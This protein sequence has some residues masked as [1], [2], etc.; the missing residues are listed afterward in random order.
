VLVP[1]PPRWAALPPYLVLPLVVVARL[2]EER[3]VA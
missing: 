1:L 3:P 2:E